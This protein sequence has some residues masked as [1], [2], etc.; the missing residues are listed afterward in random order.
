MNR[1]NFGVFAAL[2]SLCALPVW[3][4]IEYS[5]EAKLAHQHQPALQKVIC[6][7]QVFGQIGKDC[8]L[9][10]VRVLGDWAWVSWSGG[11]AGGMSVLKYSGAQWKHIYGGGGAMG[12]QD[13]IQNGVPQAIAE[14]LVP[15]LGMAFN[16]SKYR[17]TSEELISF[18]PWELVLTRNAIYARHGRIFQSKALN[19]YFLTWPWYHPTP[20]YHDGMLNSIELY[21]LNLILKY[22]KSKGYL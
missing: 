9:D 21:N 11:E 22:E 6:S 1:M 8:H 13:S 19:R 18:T 14:R 3:A 5:G 15:S 2:L 16:T 12:I 20:K 7:P 10:A 17:L 4:G